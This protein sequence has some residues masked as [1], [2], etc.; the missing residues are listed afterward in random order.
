V[1]RRGA[2]TAEFAAFEVIRRDRGVYE[3]K[4]KLD[5]RRTVSSIEM[6]I[7]GE[8]VAASPDGHRSHLRILRPRGGLEEEDERA[9]EHERTE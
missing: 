6:T 9:D 8:S 2:I 7:E 1:R 5:R 4:S 3:P